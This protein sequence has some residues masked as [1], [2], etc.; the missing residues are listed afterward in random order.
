MITM[1]D[2]EKPDLNALAHYGVLG[3]KWG[4]RKDNEKSSHRLKLEDKYQKKGF[5]S[6]E[7]EKKASDRIRV[8]K[9]LAVTGVVA[10]TAAAVAVAH[11][12]YAKNW[13][14]T[15]LDEG[16]I[17][18]RM[19]EDSSGG[20]S[21]KTFVSFTPKDN[22]H[23]AT[24]KGYTPDSKI[25]QVSLK[26]VT[27]ITAPSNHTVNKLWTEAIKENTKQIKSDN[28]LNQF[29]NT[30]FSKDS[31]IRRSSIGVVSRDSSLWKSFSKKL[32]EAGYN[33][34][35][36]YTDAGGGAE[37]PLILL[38]AISDIVRIGSRLMS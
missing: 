23:Y 2:L 28:N 38:N 36:D 34:V 15:A 14:K 37:K 1:R 27:K 19:T 8:E 11:N 18:Q 17:L 20:F 22:A 24:F 5:S 6:N 7:V 29:S 3:M 33:A 26:S 35:I 25:Y 32:Q 21:S 31:E 10:L 30:L 4:I 12:E 16:S 13:T 9:I